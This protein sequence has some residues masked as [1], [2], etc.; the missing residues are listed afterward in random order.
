M[1]TGLTGRVMLAAAAL[2]VGGCA[3]TATT[4]SGS[5]ADSELDAALSTM[6][7]GESHVTGA[8]LQRAIAEADRHPLGSPQ[9]PVRVQ[10]PPGQR[11]YLARL[12]CSDGSTP[13]FFR[14]G[15]VGIGVFGNIV[16]DYAVT[17]GSAAPVSVQMDMYHR[18]NVENRAVPG[19]T[20]TG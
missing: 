7:R 16:D 19:F 13:S 3:T 1:L 5:R 8:A 15:S 14:R 2:A 10:G 11:A 18:G 6:L 9:N 12:R 20:I 4:A 17:C